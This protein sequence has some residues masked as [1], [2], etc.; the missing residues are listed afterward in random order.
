MEA[1]IFDASGLREIGPQE[2]APASGSNVDRPTGVVTRLPQSFGSEPQSRQTERADRGEPPG[3]AAY[4]GAGSQLP[5]SAG[6]GASGAPAS[7][8]EPPGSPSY[9]G[10][11]AQQ[12]AA[13]TSRQTHREIHSD[14]S[15]FCAVGEAPGSRSYYGQSTG[16]PRNQ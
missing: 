14:S 12:S 5:A 2:G 13:S 11:T 6:S 7:V 3:S 10:K 4:F 1:L 8:G 16:A 15:A 9:F